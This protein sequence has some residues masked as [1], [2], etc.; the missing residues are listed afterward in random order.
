MFCLLPVA[1]H[2]T[3]SLFFLAH[4]ERHGNEQG[5]VR[6]DGA[7][8]ELRAKG[9]N[10]AHHRHARGQGDGQGLRDHRLA[11]LLILVGQRLRQEVRRR[12]CIVLCCLF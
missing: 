11:A 1:H 8:E 6:A 9:L 5:P 7:A 4:L 3:N 10:H 12:L 2:A